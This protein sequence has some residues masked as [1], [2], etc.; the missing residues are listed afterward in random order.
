MAISAENVVCLHDEL[1]GAGA[2]FWL[3][4][5]WGVDALLGYQSREHNDLDI[6]IEQ[7]H[8]AN[9]LN[10][11]SSRGFID[12]ASEDRRDWNFVMVHEDG[13]IIDFHVIVFDEAGNGI[14]GPVENGEAYP[15]SSF[16]GIGSIS[17]HQVR[18]L[19]ADYQILSHDSGY[20]LAEKDL[21]DVRALCVAFDL[22]V[23]PRFQ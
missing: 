4:G 17:G 11:L 7:R 6:V 2:P 20:D 14:Y 1:E 22:P 19:S 13:R 10:Y 21:A 23:P 5:G 3:D 9:A 16:I 15:A 18:C 12:V 8:L